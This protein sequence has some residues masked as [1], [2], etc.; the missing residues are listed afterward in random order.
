MKSI[1][2]VRRDNLIE[3]IRRYFDDN[4]TRM[5]ERMGQQQSVI[6]RWVKG[7]RNVGNSSA[8]KIEEISGRPQY[9]L[10]TVHTLSI[11]EIKESREYEA[12][13]YIGEVVAENLHRWMLA[14]STLNSQQRLGAKAGIAQA[15][16]QRVLS[17][18]S[19][20]TISTLAAIADAFERKPFELMVPPEKPT[21]TNHGYSRFEELTGEEKE[22]INIFIEAL[23]QKRLT[24]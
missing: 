20:T 6:S 4:Q 13:S 1:S 12:R 18:E 16:V 22:M 5:A 14:D 23:I 10:D 17:R 7:H 24:N 9:W 2:D 11:T 19:S 8:R 21:A 3:V 15:T